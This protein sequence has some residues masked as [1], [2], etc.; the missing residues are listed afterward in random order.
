MATLPT[1]LVI[2]QEVRSPETIRGTLDEELNV[3]LLC[4]HGKYP[5]HAHWECSVI[6]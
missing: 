5:F 1:V 2:D 3:L 4:L 6:H